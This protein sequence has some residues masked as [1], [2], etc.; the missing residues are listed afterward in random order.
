V[1][2]LCRALP[3]TARA[4]PDASLDEISLWLLH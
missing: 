2:N 4:K 3:A 1:I